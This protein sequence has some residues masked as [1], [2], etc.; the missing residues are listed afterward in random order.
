[1]TYGEWVEANTAE[2]LQCQQQHQE[3]HQDNG[4]E[5]AVKAA[6]GQGEEGSAEA[7]DA[8]AR[9]FFYGMA[10]VSNTFSPSLPSASADG[11]QQRHRFGFLAQALP[12]LTKDTTH[13]VLAP[14]PQKLNWHGLD[15]RL[16]WAG[17][18][19]EAHYDF[20]R[21]FIGMVAG[22]KRYLLR[23]VSH[24]SDP[25]TTIPNRM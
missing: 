11:Q 10:S 5:E 7:A 21:N 16:G 15:C 17:I 12:S 1:M 14:A 20:Q 3:Q 22:R 4:D 18:L 19:S 8:G 24:R 23:S 9:R 2:H 6:Q 25:L 13:P